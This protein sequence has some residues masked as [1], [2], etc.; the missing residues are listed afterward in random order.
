MS[1]NNGEILT[2]RPAFNLTAQAVGFFCNPAAFLLTDCVSCVNISSV[3]PL[4][5]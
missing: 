2:Y 5:K 3:V 4:H 1:G